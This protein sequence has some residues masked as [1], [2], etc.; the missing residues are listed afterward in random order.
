M[1]TPLPL[2]RDRAEPA[3]DQRNDATFDYYFKTTDLAPTWDD[4]PNWNDDAL[5]G[6]SANVA[7]LTLQR[8]TLSQAAIDN[9]M[10]LKTLISLELVNV[11]IP[12]QLVAQFHC[13]LMG[14]QVERI[15]Y[16]GEFPPEWMHPDLDQIPSN[17]YMKV[18]WF[19][20][21][22]Y[23]RTSN[24]QWLDARQ[25][26]HLENFNRTALVR[27]EQLLDT[28]IVRAADC[29]PAC[30]ALAH[31]RVRHLTLDCGQF[32]SN[33]ARG[34]G[35]NTRIESVTLVDLPLAREW[36]H[37]MVQ[38]S[39]MQSLTFV[40]PRPVPIGGAYLKPVFAPPV[41]QDFVTRLMQDRADEK[42][43]PIKLAIKDRI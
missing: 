39:R 13:A 26:L 8:G 34:L 16:T 40:R 15:Y 27:G 38:T 19:P 7:H 23:V 17:I 25:S 12:P 2:A 37:Q 10:R 9:M 5:M 43:P 42:R 32:G 21:D 30:K 24:V 6:L 29:D 4:R 14:R 20:E 18:A 41:N 35:W 36:V 22:R 1:L 28:L 3:F 31:L 11:D 33:T